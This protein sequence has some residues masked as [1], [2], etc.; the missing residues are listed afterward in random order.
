MAADIKLVRKM[1]LTLPGVTEGVCFGTPAFY[2]RKKLMLRLR[3]D[4]ETLVVKFPPQER[5]EAIE[6]QPDIFSV[7][8]HYENYPV[9]LVSLLAVGE[10]MLSGLIEDAWRMLASRKQIAAFEA[11]RPNKESNILA[12]TRREK[13]LTR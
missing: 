5:E 7:T 3:E 8:D 6:K 2:L 13:G 12:W 11:D 10:N 4:G 9:V 1:A